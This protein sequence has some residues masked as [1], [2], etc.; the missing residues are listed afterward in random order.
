MNFLPLILGFLLLKSFGMGRSSNT[1]QK[2]ENAKNSD[3]EN[4]KNTE[5]IFGNGNNLMNTL[6]DARNALQLV[7]TFNKMKENKADLA[8]VMGEIMSNPIALNFV[9]KMGFGSQPKEDDDL[10]FLKT[11]SQSK[12]NGGVASSFDTNEKS[13][14]EEKSKQNAPQGVRTQSCGDEIL[15]DEQIPNLHI[16]P[17]DTL[18]KPV[19]NIA[20][21]EL[22]GELKKYYENWYIK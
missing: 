21:V 10:D 19:E 14:Q 12:K 9:G 6:E 13:P 2:E 7:N 1:S 20:G 5:G 16:S 11:Y 4:A 17:S 8:E 15:Q 22:T 18:F 3:E